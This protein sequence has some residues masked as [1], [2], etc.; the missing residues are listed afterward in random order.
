PMGERHEAL[1]QATREA[2]QN[3]AKH[4]GGPISVY[5]EATPARSEVFVRD[6]GPGFGPRQVPP[7]RLGV[8]E[9]LIG[10]MERNGGTA[11]IR[12]TGNGT[13]VQ[14]SLDHVEEGSTS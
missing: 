12:N 13:E 3:A 8:R 11:R 5:L 1:V 9:S 4:A 10:R 2:V 6:R 7:D 14:L